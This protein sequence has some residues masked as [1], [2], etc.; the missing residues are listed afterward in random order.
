M[1]NKNVIMVIRTNLTE[2]ADV[3]N[4]QLDAFMK[5]A[6]LGSFGKAADAMFISTPALIQQ[7][8]LLEAK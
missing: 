5:A 3:Y 4:H 7:I 1:K 8:N 2:V 6:E